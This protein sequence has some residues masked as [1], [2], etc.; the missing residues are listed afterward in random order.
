MSQG[1]F[2]MGESKRRKRAED[3]FRSAIV[4]ATYRPAKVFVVRRPGTSADEFSLLVS[5]R[6]VL[7]NAIRP[8]IHADLAS[9]PVEGGIDPFAASVPEPVCYDVE[10]GVIRPFRQEDE[11]GCVAGWHH[12]VVCRFAGDPVTRSAS[13][14][15][16]LL[17]ADGSATLDPGASLRGLVRV[18]GLG[19][20]IVEADASLFVQVTCLRA[21]TLLAAG[22]KANTGEGE[23]LDAAGH[24]LVHLQALHGHV[25]RRTD[26]GHGDWIDHGALRQIL[27]EGLAIEGEDDVDLDAE[28]EGEIE[29]LWGYASRY[30][31]DRV[32]S[33]MGPAL[34][35]IPEAWMSR[36][37]PGAG[38]SFEA[39][40]KAMAGTSPDGSPASNKAEIAFVRS[41]EDA[42]ADARVRDYLGGLPI[43]SSKDGFSLRRDGDLLVGAMRSG[44][45][46][47]LLFSPPEDGSER[48]V[49]PLMTEGLLDVDLGVLGETR[50]R[51]AELEALGFVPELPDPATLED[52]PALALLKAGT[53]GATFADLCATFGT[54][55]RW[56]DRSADEADEFRL[57]AAEEE[58]LDPHEQET[59]IRLDA[60]E[61]EAAR[62]AD[63]LADLGGKPTKRLEAL[64]GPLFEFGY[65]SDA[66]RDARLLVDAARSGATLQDLALAWTLI[67]P[68]ADAVP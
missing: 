64:L 56:P 49:D 33:R 25:L 18:G 9:I 23:S 57:D 29:F 42:V 5:A 53:E 55:M 34:L 68:E 52:Y 31:A 3:E 27:S 48:L 19:Q 44:E 39:V 43:L 47:Q 15:H 58:E 21:E 22:H 28:I 1:V 7:P 38:V 12:T 35:V 40:D 26:L 59:E 11:E 8:P 50:D 30:P 62:L 54:L 45:F 32:C 16:G 51:T 6:A 10:A 46:L 65:R 41:G 36:S 17:E 2:V 20:A 24:H 60:L 67:D 37:E 61:A 66:E 13:I 14:S 63:R 4:E